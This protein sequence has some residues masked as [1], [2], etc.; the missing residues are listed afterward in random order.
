MT[1]TGYIALIGRPNS[2]KSSFLNALL[3]ADVSSVSP[4]P[5]TT[6][7]TIHGI[8]TEWETQII[9]L[10]TPGIHEGTSTLTSRINA[11]ALSSVRKADVILYFLDPTRANWPEE[12]RIE[13]LLETVRTPVIRVGTK[14]DIP[15]RYPHADIDVHIS[16]LTRVWFQE[17]IQ[18]ITPLLPLW[19]H[20][21]D[22]SY[23]TIQETEFRIAEVIREALFQNLSEEVP[24]AC[25]VEVAER[26][27][28]EIILK[29]LAYI[30]AETESQKA[31]V[32]GK[33]GK[34][35]GEI[36]KYARLKLE[37]I[38]GKKVYLALR[39]K[40][41]RNWRKDQK[42]LDRLFPKE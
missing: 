20:L 17:L 38:F 5:Q 24:Y 26:E 34:R 42:I 25:Y 22:E 7:R 21:Y 16:A 36:G 13:S 33:N 8:Y 1:R 18:K 6:Q 35:L 19:P 23:Y 14:A 30:H 40:V 31:I 9:F 11:Q 27:D 41:S 28:T 15:N 32:I 39:V 10:D 2:G 3:E 12:K 37:S 29:I 4:L